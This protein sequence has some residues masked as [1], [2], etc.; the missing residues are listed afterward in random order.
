MPVMD[1]QQCQIP[2]ISTYFPLYL[3]HLI[4]ALYTRINMCLGYKH[5]ITKGKKQGIEINSN[6]THKNYELPTT[7]K[8][9]KYFHILVYLENFHSQDEIRNVLGLVFDG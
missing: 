4:L 7:L 6:S 3:L 9:F 2:D 5:Q 8:F 1:I